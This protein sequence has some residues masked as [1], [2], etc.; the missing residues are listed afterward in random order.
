[1]GKAPVLGSDFSEDFQRDKD[2]TSS[3]TSW[4]KNPGN[5]KSFHLEKQDCDVKKYESG[6]RAAFWNVL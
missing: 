2:T 3:G 5:I 4:V 6:I 1:M